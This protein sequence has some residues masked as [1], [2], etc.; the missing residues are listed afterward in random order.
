MRRH[1]TLVIQG[2]VSATLLT[3]LF[4]GVDWAEL[5][6][7]IARL[8]LSLYLGA[9]A[10]AVAGQVLYAFKWF[11]AVRAVG[12]DAG[13]GGVLSRYVVGIF[14]NNFL[15]S[16]IGGDWAKVYYL[17]REDGYLAAVASVFIDRYLG[18]LYLVVLAA[19][20]MWR[21][22]Y[23][24][25]AWNAARFG[26]TLA[27]AAL[28]VIAVVALAVP[29]GRTAGALA[30]RA[31]LAGRLARHASEAAAHVREALRRPSVLASGAMVVLLYFLMQA[32]VYGYVLAAL[33]GLQLGFV[34]LLTAV[35]AIAAL[36]MVP[37][38][39]NGL[40]LREQL[41]VVLLAALGVPRE[42]AFAVA[43]VLFSHLVLISVAG[44]VLWLRAWRSA[45]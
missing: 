22:P 14:F 2:L 44:L 20:L 6:A 33:A 37:I 13:F 24:D 45:S 21:Q 29:A 15:P 41:H 23:S 38:A 36:S 17:G 18:A 4:R 12:I 31:G 1:L 30:D 19:V 28:L 42:V 40:G 7:V 25:P 8:P 9:L 3:L 32:V 10:I 5:R 16:T 39:M 11:V 43:V 35:T 26:L 27:A 34:Q